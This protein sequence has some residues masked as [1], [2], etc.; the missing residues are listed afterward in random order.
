[1]I[2]QLY[3]SCMHACAGISEL[4]VRRFRAKVAVDNGASIGL[5]KNKLGFKEVC[6]GMH[7]VR[8]SMTQEW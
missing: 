4:N 5:F 6:V 8:S 7:V 3:L 2:M 1:M